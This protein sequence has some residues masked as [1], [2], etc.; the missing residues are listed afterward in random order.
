LEAVK[1]YFPPEVKYV[2]PEGGFY[3]WVELPQGVSARKVLDYA[4]DNGVVFVSGKSFSPDDSLT[5]AFRIA[6]S[7]VDTGQI[8]EG[9]RIIGEGIRQAMIAKVLSYNLSFIKR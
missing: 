6:Y 5:G 8:D 9:I 7:N 2:K 4:L 1:K 3:L